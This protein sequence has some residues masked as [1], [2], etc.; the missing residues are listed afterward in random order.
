MKQEQKKQAY[1]I[2]TE[3]KKLRKANPGL[4]FME[5]YR[6]ACKILGIKITD[7]ANTT[8]DNNQGKAAKKEASQHKVDKPNKT[9]KPRTKKQPSKK[10]SSKKSVGSKKATAPKK[11]SR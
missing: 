10:D 2:G 7:H 9:G 6:A 4:P 3:V 1:R 11:S 5:Y 8:A